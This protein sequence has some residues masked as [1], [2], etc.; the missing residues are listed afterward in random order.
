LAEVGRRWRAGAR[1]TDALDALDDLP[2]TPLAPVVRALRDGER[3]GT[4]LVPA[5]DE[6]AATLRDERRRRAAA[7]ARR[8]PIV[9]LFPLVLCVLPAFVLLTVV[10]LL[11]TATASLRL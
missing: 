6:V 3:D 11:V 10:P 8:A 9:L 1:F 4:P 5:L 7:S 2:G